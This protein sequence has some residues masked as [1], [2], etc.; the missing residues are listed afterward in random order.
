M[1]ALHK[2]I[3]LEVEA[4]QRN[5]QYLRNLLP[6]DYILQNVNPPKDEEN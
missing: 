2:V 1:G 5:E 3:P 4:G 6:Q